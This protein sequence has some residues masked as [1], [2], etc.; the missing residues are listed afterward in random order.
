[1]D[2]AQINLILLAVN[3]EKYACFPVIN[4]NILGYVL[5]KG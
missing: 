1:M 2:L 4:K 3:V 5:L